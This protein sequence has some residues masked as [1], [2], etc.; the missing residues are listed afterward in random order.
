MT[1][2]STCLVSA[3][4]TLAAGLVVA[5]ALAKDGP[6]AAVPAVE[7]LTISASTR[8][9]VELVGDQFRPAS[10]AP[11]EDALLTF[12]TMIAA[13]Y[14][15]GGV[16]VGGEI[17][18][19]RSYLQQPNSSARE[20]NALEPVQAYVA[21]AIQPVNGW[22]GTVKAGRFVLDLGSSR[23]IGRTDFSNIVNSYAG[24]VAD[25]RSKGKDR[26]T[27]FWT[28]PFATLPDTAAGTL[29]NEVELDRATSDLQL[30]GVHASKAAIGHGFGAEAYVYRLAERDAVDRLTR[31]RRL[32][33]FGGR[34]RRAPAK[35]RFDAELEVAGQRGETRLSAAASD[36]RD[37]R[38]NAAFA[39]AEAGWTWAAAWTPRIS[40]LFDY[41]SG[42]GADADSYGRFDS[43][44]GAGRTDLGP[45]G[46]FS[47]AA[48]ANLVSPGVKIE[49]KPTKR[50][51]SFFAA[52]MIWLDSP[53]DSVG[54]VRDRNGRVGGDAGTQLETRLRFWLVPERLRLEGGAAYLAKGRFLREAPNAPRN[55]DTRFAYFEV[56]AQF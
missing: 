16:S 23:L 12:R 6:P 29:D 32:V 31:N 40:A 48:R 47:A 4:G 22:K 17:V 19:V 8:A 38:V 10:S 54:G 7:R 49:V 13:E 11:G 24:V 42:D 33:T 2:R 46:L 45:R 56:A 44:Y 14:D 20:S 52:R 28:M 55:G 53:T 26:L 36:R 1:I 25:F 9:R 37:V 35:G 21:V 41:A 34:L 15:L 39:H 30:F 3:F 18:D 51:D 27:A 43:L 50:F 5:P